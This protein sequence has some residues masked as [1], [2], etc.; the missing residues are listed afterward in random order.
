MS[1]FLFF[2]FF[3]DFSMRSII[4]LPIGNLVDINTGMLLISRIF[5]LFSSCL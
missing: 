4:G 5:N 3:G 2:F 1:L